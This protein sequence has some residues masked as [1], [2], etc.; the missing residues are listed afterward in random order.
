MS[1][2]CVVG[3]TTIRLKNRCTGEE[4]PPPSEGTSQRKMAG[5][6][7]TSLRKEAAGCRAC[8]L[9]EHAT[10]TVFGE[11]PATAQAMFVGEQPGDHEDLEGQ[12]FVGPAG[13]L[14][15]EALELA[16]VDRSTVYVT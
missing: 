9:W 4:S 12:P 14:L 16:G 1:R 3:R 6:T 11:G 2:R 5:R 13:R 8:G 15:D 10:Q 7:L